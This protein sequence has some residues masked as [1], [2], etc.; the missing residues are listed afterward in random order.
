MHFTHGRYSLILRSFGGR[1]GRTAARETEIS[2][3][4]IRRTPFASIPR[5]RVIDG[6]GVGWTTAETSARRTGG[7]VGGF[8]RAS[9][10]TPSDRGGRRN[11]DAF[12]LFNRRTINQRRLDVV[13]AKIAIESFES[14]AD[15]RSVESLTRAALLFVV[16]LLV[17]IRVV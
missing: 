4:S 10:W 17:V 14:S 12:G 11:T 15:V 7:R 8:G 1:R 3:P 6:R 16:V 5:V 9:D 2:L 13:P